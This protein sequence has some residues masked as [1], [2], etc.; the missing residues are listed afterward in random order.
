MVDLLL[1]AVT[2]AHADEA[3]GLP[4]IQYEIAGHA[5]ALRMLSR[6]ALRQLRRTIGLRPTTS[7]RKAWR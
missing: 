6:V 3:A 2:A 7:G 5:E 4:S 1:P